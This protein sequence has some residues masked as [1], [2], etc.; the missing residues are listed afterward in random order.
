MRRQL[1]LECAPG[2]ADEPGASALGGSAGRVAS[3]TVQPGSSAGMIGHLPPAPAPEESATPIPGDRPC[4]E[5]QWQACHPEL[6][7]YVHSRVD[8]SVDVDDII[9]EALARLLRYRGDPEVQDVRLMLFRIANNLL[10]DYYRRNERQHAD[11]HVALDLAGPLQAPDKPHV[12]RVAHEQT[13]D[14]LMRAIA[15]LPPKCRLAFTLSRFDAIP[16]KEIARRMGVSVKA[17]EKHLARA[18]LACKA[19]AGD[20]DA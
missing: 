3:R 12:D 8:N 11:G 17:V 7:R 14:R 18:M 5:Q 16:H 19:A 13:L 2:D 15:R 1:A 10:T 6:V 4:F 9:Q 20:H